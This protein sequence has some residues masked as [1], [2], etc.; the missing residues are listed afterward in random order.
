MALVALHSSA[1]SLS[2][3]NTDL[4]VI[5]NNLAN[6]NTDG[7]KASR[8]NFQD[9]LY[10]EKALPGVENANGDLRPTGLYV[11]LGV[12]VSGTQVDFAQGAPRNTGRALDLL[13]DGEGFFQVTVEDDRGANGIGYTRAGNFAIN[14]DGEIVLAN[15]QGRRLQPSIS[16]PDDTIQIEINAD[17]RVFVLQPGEAE[18]TEVGQIELAVFVNPQGL[19]QIGENLFVETDGSGPPITGEPAQANFGRIQAG[20]LESSNVDPTMELIRLI[21]TQRAFEM[22]SNVIRA[23]DETL[24]AVATLRR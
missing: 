17:G 24:R 12:K 4:D 23:A 18:A 7:F 14:R 10:Q 2:A 5:A 21:R 1:T 3:L 19:K 9:L 13:I 16:V 11:G 8:V 22:N 6:V 20:F 15:D